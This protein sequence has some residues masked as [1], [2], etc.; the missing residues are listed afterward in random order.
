MRFL[1][2]LGFLLFLIS[3]SIEEESD[4]FILSGKTGN[5]TGFIIFGKDTIGI[6]N[7]EFTDSIQLKASQYEYIQLNTWK[8]P[9]LIY[10]EKKKNLNIDFSKARI[11]VEGD[12]LNS[13]L[14]NIDSILI[15]YSLRWDMEEE[16]FRKTLK[17][18]L[19]AN[20][21]K[22]D[23]LFLNQPLSED[24]IDELKQIEKLKVA[25][26]TANFIS[27][28]Q[29]NEINIDRNIYDFLND[30]NLNNNRLEKQVNNR[31][32]QH[33]YL[34]DKVSEELPDSLYPF[35]AIDTV[36]KYSHIESIRKMIISSVVKSS[37]YSEDVNHDKLLATFEN[38]FGKLEKDDELLM[39]YDRIQ[40][41]KPGNSA[42]SIGELEGFNGKLTTIED[43]RGTNI[44]IT[45]WGTWCPYCKEE[46]PYIKELV[47][48]YESKLQVVAISLDSDKSKWKNYIKEHDW[49]GIHLIDSKRN[50]TLKSN[51]L[52]GGTNIHVLI[53]KNGILMSSRGMKP[54]SS[55]LENLIKRLN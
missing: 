44:L 31:N 28:Q 11:K 22:I 29:R 53:D 37:F 17:S 35:A 14:L 23:S 13:Y 41:L 12:I 19:T 7:G 2:F 43:L 51:Y 25:H 50:S 36:N 16:I 47:N 34:L 4:L 38:N 6:N 54:S 46:L 40:S 33:Y 42:P 9:K 5:E 45:V 26:R 10:A 3:C 1:L 48:K 15:P 30:V 39:I 20:F 49:D 55:E 32:F 8:W 24:Q 18:E 52:I 21:K 27:F